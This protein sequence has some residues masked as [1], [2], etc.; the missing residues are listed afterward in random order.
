MLKFRDIKNTTVGK[1]FKYKPA[2][3]VNRIFNYK[4]FRL[5]EKKTEKYE[6]KRK[7]IESKK[8]IIRKFA[9]R[10]L[11]SRYQIRS[12]EKLIYF[13]KIHQ[14]V[15]LKIMNNSYDV[16]IQTQIK[17]LKWIMYKTHKEYMYALKSIILSEFFHNLKKRKKIL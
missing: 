3:G 10:I 16:L 9:T 14:R 5:W 15:K 1:K 11:K 8:R 12:W 4:I 13:R 2:T 6:I 7:I 17:S